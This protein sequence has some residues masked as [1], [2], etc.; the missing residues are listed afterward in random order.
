M[1]R[2]LRKIPLI[3]VSAAIIYL[4]LKRGDYNEPLFPHIDK[5]KHLIAYSALGFTIFLATGRTIFLKVLFCYGVI[6]GLSLE[7]IQGL[8]PYRDMSLLDGIA[9]ILGLIT[10]WRVYKVFNNLTRG[11]H[12]YFPS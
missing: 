12:P 7:Y 2:V 4:S 9:N 11:V 3:L 1:L 8:L 10:G 6:L 5:V